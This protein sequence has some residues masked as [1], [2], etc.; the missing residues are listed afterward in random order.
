MRGSTLSLAVLIGT[1]AL[2]P[3]STVKAQKA[4]GVSEED[5]PTTISM[6]RR[7]DVLPAPTGP[8][9]QRN[10]LRVAGQMMGDWT[11]ELGGVAIDGR[12]LQTLADT[13]V[14]EPLERAIREELKRPVDMPDFFYFLDD[15]C[16]AS[17]NGL[18]GKE[19]FITPSRA[20][21]TGIFLHPDDIFGRSARV[22]GEGRASELPVDK[23]EEPVDLEPASDGDMLGPNWSA[24]FP[25]ETVESDALEHIERERPGTTFDN[26]VQSLISQ[27]RAHGAEVSLESTVRPRERGYLMWGAFHLSK[28]KNKRQVRQR[29]RELEKVNKAWGLNVQILWS[30]PDGWEATREAARLMADAYD[31][32][33]ATKGGAK[34][35]KHYGGVAVDV[36]AY[37]MPRQVKLDA[38]DGTSRIFDLSNPSQ[39]RDLSLTPEMIGWIETHFG[40]KKLKRDHPH[41]DDG[42]Q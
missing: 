16:D 28:A 14:P 35:S 12:R 29:L 39:P 11:I 18:F 38:P 31:V 24:R 13:P 3:S 23:P 36:V 9:G 25:I 6:N 20:R 4:A 42:Q 27:L 33:Y 17:K 37:G 1:C 40:F 41:W 26:R 32:V 21:N 7:F 19:V 5:T 15:L 30:H 34:K 22:Y 10:A 2:F 8:V